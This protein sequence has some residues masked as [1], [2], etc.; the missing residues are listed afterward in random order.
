MG[1]TEFKDING[2]IMRSPNGTRYY[3]KVLNDG[4]LSTSPV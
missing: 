2:I 4:S 1:A 3:V